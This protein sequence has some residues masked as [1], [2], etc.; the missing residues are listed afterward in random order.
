MLKACAV[1]ELDKRHIFRIARGSNP[2]A[3]RGFR[4]D[5]VLVFKNFNNVGML[6]NNTL[7]KIKIASI[8]PKTLGR[9]D[10][11]RGAT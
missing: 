5:K 10:A 6:H 7:Q 9:I 3:D 8:V 1:V 4:A 11:I 2:A